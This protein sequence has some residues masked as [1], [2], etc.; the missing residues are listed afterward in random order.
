MKIG[1][2]AGVA[3]VRISRARQLGAWLLVPVAAIAASPLVMAA[4]PP[5]PVTAQLTP[6]ATQ[7]LTPDA[8]AISEV[9]LLAAQNQFQ[10]I[11]ARLAALR[12]SRRNGSQGLALDT[13]RPARNPATSATS[14]L[15]ASAAE[16]APDSQAGADFSRWGFFASGTFEN[17]DID[18][19]LVSPGS[20]YAIQGIVAGVDYRRSDRWVLGGALGITRQDIDLQANLGDVD[21]DAWTISGYS[22]YANANNWYADG[23]L[24]YGHANYDLR[25]VAGGQVLTASPDGNSWS[26]TGTVGRDFARGGWN[27]GP[28]ARLLYT[29]I[30][31]DRFTEQ[32]TGAG[33]LTA[34]DIHTRGQTSLSSVLGAKFTY[35]HSTGS[36]VLIPHFGV[37]WQHEFQDDPAVVEASLSG[38]PGTP[39]VFVGDEPDGNYFR[40]GAG[41]S[42]VFP[43]GRSGFIY[44]ERLLGRER[45]SDGSLA[46]GLR[47]E[48]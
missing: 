44:Y 21:A 9:S 17:G 31:F 43:Q 23:V 15:S 11:K 6:T 36:G 32:V 45:Y 16:G 8:L 47:I 4:G 19:G 7:G 46:I 27:F 1:T 38:V 34:Q 12:S 14:S 39:L 48:F 10:N 40:L 37:E 3:V 29:D 33:P 30:E 35:A 42:F 26:F 18:A 5:L 24:S 41:M 22:S 20:D 25:R 2:H 28:Y 13:T